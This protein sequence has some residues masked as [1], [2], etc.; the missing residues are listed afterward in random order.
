[1]AAT[2]TTHP[3][4]PRLDVEERRRQLIAIGGEL[5]S[6]RSFD[7]ISIDEIADAAGI[8]KGLLYHYFP[9]KRHF[10]VATISAAADR[11]V[12]SATGGDAATSE[13]PLRA[14]IDAY[15]D[16]V[17]DHEQGYVMLMQGG[18]GSDGEVRAI[19]DA[20]RDRFVRRILGGDDRGPAMALAVRGWIG[21]VEGA[22]LRWLEDR[23][24]GRETLRELYAGSLAAA[25]EQAER[26]ER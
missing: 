1:M 2:E 22:T 11:L 3:A 10:Y 8:S 4:P 17:E 20:T 23:A 14:G 6:R 12:A 13:D 21:F 5:F 15:L 24:V 7:G 19:V 9:S 26:L 18:I 25:V 16:Y